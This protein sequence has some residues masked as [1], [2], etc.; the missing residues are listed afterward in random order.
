VKQVNHSPALLQAIDQL[1]S[2]NPAGLSE[3]EL[4][5]ALD[6]QHSDLFPKPNFSE[7]VLLFQHHFML[8]HCLYRL[9]N[10]YAHLGDF[11]L[12]I[13]LSRLVKHPV[14]S[15]KQ[16]L[17]RHDPLRE[18]YLNLSNMNKESE[19]SIESLLNSFWTRLSHFNAAPEAHKTLG[20]T[21]NESH[22]EKQQRYRKLA[23]KHHPDKGGN[24]Q[25]FDRIQQAWKSIR[26]P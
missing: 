20:L 17:E 10:E 2:I 11:R 15:P 9:Q 6:K 19:S 4:M 25:E 21:G 23:Q 16:D 7:K 12:E 26:K 8:R 22:Q 13:G 3:Y 5:A 1:L 18:Y 14:T 24:A